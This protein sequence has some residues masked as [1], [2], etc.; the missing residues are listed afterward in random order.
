MVKGPQRMSCARVTLPSSPGFDHRGLTPALPSL[1]IPAS[2]PSLQESYKQCRLG[3]RAF[4]FTSINHPH[5]PASVCNCP[6]QTHLCFINP[7]LWLMCCPFIHTGLLLLNPDSR[8][9]WVSAHYW[10]IGEWESQPH[11]GNV[12]TA[13]LNH[14]RSE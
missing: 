11:R 1:S 2:P 9:A 4:P 3:K 12:L 8:V 6:V 7:K 13:F 14:S 10:N 5:C